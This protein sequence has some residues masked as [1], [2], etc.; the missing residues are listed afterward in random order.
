MSQTQVKGRRTR[1]PRDSRGR[2]ISATNHRLR[3]LDGGVASMKLR[4]D[5]VMA[6]RPGTR[7][8]DGPPIALLRLASPRT[9]AEFLPTLAAARSVA[10]AR[11]P[12]RPMR[13]PSAGE[14][15]QRSVLS[16]GLIVT[17]RPGPEQG[18][19]RIRKARHAP[20]VERYGWRG[21]RVLGTHGSSAG[22]RPRPRRDRSK[23]SSP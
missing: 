3:T 16:M 21:D 18:L 10:R 22:S 20:K 9:P 17:A 11:P 7:A 19:L 1:G 2:V 5:E 14:P 13:A 15:V 8:G 4:R 6:A 12:P 23:S